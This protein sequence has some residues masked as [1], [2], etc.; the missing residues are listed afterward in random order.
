MR[1]K[2]NYADNIFFLAIMLKTLRNGF[3]LDLDAEYFLHKFNAE[4]SFVKES[5]DM[6]LASLKRSSH[7]I[8]RLEY[9]RNLYRVERDFALL[10]DDVAT[11]RLPFSA[12]FKP[13]V[14]S[15]REVRKG[16][17]KDIS[18]IRKV[19]SDGGKQ[20]IADEYTVSEQEFKSLLAEEGYEPPV[21]ARCLLAVF[22]SH[23]N[24]CISC[25]S[26]KNTG[27]FDQACSTH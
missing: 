6:I 17:L 5:L 25:R 23:N 19:L 13:F 3:K 2:T 15:Y 11:Q 20:G 27:H 7:M 24:V 1:R 22:I 26:D 4:I 16:H 10:L 8:K 9:M 12:A 14:D 21:C 18:E